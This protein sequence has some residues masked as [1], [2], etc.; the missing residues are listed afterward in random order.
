MECA[1]TT[2]APYLGPG[3]PKGP[4]PDSPPKLPNLISYH[5]PGPVGYQNQ[6]RYVIMEYTFTTC[7]PYLG[8]ELQG[9]VKFAFVKFEVCVY[10][11]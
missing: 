11:V 1:F 3:S 9:L 10:E 8:L 2:C 7:T 4:G 6:V 5:V